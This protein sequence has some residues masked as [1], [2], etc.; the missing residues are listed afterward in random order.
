VIRVSE[1]L[2]GESGGAEIDLIG[3]VLDAIRA[4]PDEALRDVEPATV[5][6]PPGSPEEPVE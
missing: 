4:V 1:P 5:Y 2:S 3:Q 6:V